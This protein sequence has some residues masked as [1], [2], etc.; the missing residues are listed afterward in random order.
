MIGKG[1]H[2]MPALSKILVLLAL[3]HE[4]QA[5]S[6]RSAKH[7]IGLQEYFKMNACLDANGAMIAN[8]KSAMNVMGHYFSR[9]FIR[10]SHKLVC[11]CL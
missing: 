6:L 11:T 8:P 3:L 4:D 5:L 7:L 2:V 10:L 1:I 9:M